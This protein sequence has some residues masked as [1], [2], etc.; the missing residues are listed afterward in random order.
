MQFIS[1]PNL[2]ISPKILTLFLPLVLFGI[3][4][5]WTKGWL[6]QLILSIYLVKYHLN[7]S[8]A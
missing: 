8:G 2:I 3:M 4:P 6:Q 5:F 7:L 1:I